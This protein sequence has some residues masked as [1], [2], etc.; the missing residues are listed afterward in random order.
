MKVS[1]RK[2]QQK[3]CA[4]CGNVFNT[5]HPKRRYCDKCQMLSYVELH[6]ND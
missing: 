2:L 5:T 1:A 4:H 3:I 6:K